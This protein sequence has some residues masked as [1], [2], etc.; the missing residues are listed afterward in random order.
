MS[1]I[2]EN[3]FER[4]FIIGYGLAGGFGGERNFEVI[5][6]DTQE[7][8]EEWAYEVCCEEYERYAGSNGLREIGEIMEEENIEDEDEAQQVFEEERES[9]LA[10]S[11][12]PYSK[13]YEKKVMYHH[14]HN[15]YKEITGDCED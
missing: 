4:L 5:Q 10:Y 3:K 11:A 1:E 15:P 6:V 2:K 7:Q 13:E 12:Q 14:Y 9:W 8:A